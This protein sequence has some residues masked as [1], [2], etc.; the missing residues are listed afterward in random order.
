MSDDRSLI[1]TDPGLAFSP[2]VFF[3]FGLIA[4]GVLFTLDNLGWIEADNLFDY[5]PLILIAVG[6]GKLLWPGSRS[7]R[8]SGA[9]F[10]GLGVLILGANLELWSISVFDLWPLVIVVVGANLVWRGV[11]GDRSVPA[12]TART[13]N[14]LA[15]L[16][17]SR[18]VNGSEDFRGGDVVAFMG[19]AEID[20]REAGILIEPAVIDAF[21]MWGGVEIIVPRD[22]TVVCRGVPLLGGYVNNTEPPSVD[23][24]QRLVVKGF[25]IMGGVDVRNVKA[26]DS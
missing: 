24:G 2:R 15:V 9:V 5:W 18:R 19:G 10:T 3:G 6:L 13:V 23:T 1:Q 7:G 11:F 25:A 17:G 12:E 14:A 21:A 4:L 22:W 16:G 8:M 26:S 20:L